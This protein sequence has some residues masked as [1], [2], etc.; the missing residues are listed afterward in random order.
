M[1]V[2]TKTGDKGETSL[3]GGKRVRKDNIRLE[4]YG[5][6]DEL[7]SFIGMI[8]NFPIDDY[9]KNLLAFIQNKLFDIGSLL[10]AEVDGAEYPLPKLNEITKNEI[11]VLEQSIDRFDSNL[12]ELKNFII[13]AGSEIISWCNISRTV[14]RRAERRIISIEDKDDKYLQIIVFINRLSDLLFIM[15]R[16]YAKDFNIEEI[17]WNNDL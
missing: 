8:R 1:K 3:L 7:N 13:P 12:S 10:A 4:A 6:I 5:T 2:Y 15:G 16:K 9:D 14:C 17:L 11:S